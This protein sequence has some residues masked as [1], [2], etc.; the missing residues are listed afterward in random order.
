MFFCHIETLK[1][2]NLVVKNEN[3]VDFRGFR[4][5]FRANSRSPVA[6]EKYLDHANSSL[7]LGVL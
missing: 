6:N 3:I 2:S 5:H 1:C 7:S 4:G